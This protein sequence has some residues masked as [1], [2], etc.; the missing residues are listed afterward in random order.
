LGQS[1]DE[2]WD[3]WELFVAATWTLLRKGGRFGLLVPDTIF[4]PDKS[5]TRRFLKDRFILE[6]VYSLGP[7]WFG[8]SVRMGT[9]VIQGVKQ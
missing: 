9:V 8:P 6:K 1:S 4:S 5:K 7:D 2:E 3:S